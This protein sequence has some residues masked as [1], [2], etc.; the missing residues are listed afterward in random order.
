MFLSPFGGPGPQVEQLCSLPPGCP[1]FEIG[2]RGTCL[3]LAM[4]NGT[5]PPP[6]RRMGLAKPRLGHVHDDLRQGNGEDLAGA[7]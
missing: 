2:H 7:T 3:A 4:G 6:G 5:G 1:K